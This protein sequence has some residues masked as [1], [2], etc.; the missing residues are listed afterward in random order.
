M[1]I[2][3]WSSDV[4]SSDLRALLSVARGED[5][6]GFSDTE[7]NAGPSG[8]HGSIHWLPGSSFN[9]V[10]GAPDHVDAGGESLGWLEILVGD[11][12]GH[13]PA[14][15]IGNARGRRGKRPSE[16]GRAHV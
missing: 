3:D 12:V 14:L 6:D 7:R 8:R 4:C 9:A 2:S 16:I 11:V 1:R 13:R 15:L 5:R 10:L